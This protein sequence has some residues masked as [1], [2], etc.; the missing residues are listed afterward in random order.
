MGDS[1]LTFFC[2]L[3]HHIVGSQLRIPK[4]LDIN[5]LQ[6]YT[7]WRLVPRGGSKPQGWTDKRSD[8]NNGEKPLMQRFSTWPFLSQGS[9]KTSLH[10]RYL[11]LITVAKCNYEVATKMASWFGVTAQRPALK[12]C[13]IRKAKNHCSKHMV[14]DF[15]SVF[16]L[17]LDTLENYVLHFLSLL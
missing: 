17:Q 13:S 6:M 11:R 2:G 9:P 3:G 14:Y 15:F 16:C 1:D 5:Y 12:G 4:A 10:M 7:Y 8:M